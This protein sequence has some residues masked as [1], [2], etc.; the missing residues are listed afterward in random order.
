ML[1]FLFEY[2][3]IVDDKKSNRIVTYY[4]KDDIYTRYKNLEI[5]SEDKWLITRLGYLLIFDNNKKN[6]AK[7][8]H[9]NKIKLI[10]RRA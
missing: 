4:F 1:Q 8:N 2:V 6:F 3:I 5:I 10:L 9:Q 7:F